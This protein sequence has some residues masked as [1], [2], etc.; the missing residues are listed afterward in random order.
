MSIWIERKGPSGKKEWL[1]IDP[2]P[3]MLYAILTVIVL[4]IIVPR[5]LSTASVALIAFGLI[6]LT[7]T[8][9]SLFRQGI[10]ISWGTKRMTKWNAR[11]YWAGYV[12]LGLG[13]IA[14]FMT[15]S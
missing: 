11:L 13:G 6:C 8:K 15:G 4:A 5:F 9:A 1:L 10:W 12:L 7:I 2:E 14:L 3:L